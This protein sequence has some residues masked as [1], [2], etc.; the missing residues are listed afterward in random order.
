MEVKPGRLRAAGRLAPCIILVLGCASDRGTVDAGNSATDGAL[1]EA[2]GDAASPARPEA[3]TGLTGGSACDASAQCLSGACTLGACSDWPHAMRIRI[4][5][6]AAGAD[7]REAV[8]DFPLLLRLDATNFPFAEAR[9]DGTDIRFVDPSGRSLSHEVERWDGDSGVAALWV[10]VPRIEGDSRN[11]SVLM[12]WGNSL[13]VPTSSGPSV[14][15]AFACVLHMG[16]APDGV[17]SHLGDSSGQG[18]IGL[19]QNPTADALSADGIAGLGL[20]LDGRSTYLA[21][22]VASTSPPPFSVSLWLKTTSSTHA[23]IAGFASKASGNDV[24]FDRA[25]EM[26]ES[27]R[28]AFGVLNGGHLLTVSTLTGYN[29]GAWHLIVARLSSG[30]QYLFVDGEPVAD[31]PT[32]SGEDSYNGY[33]RFGEEPLP[34]PPPATTD[35][36]VPTGNFFSGALDEIRVT[37]DEPSDARIKLAYATQRPGTNAVSYQPVP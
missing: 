8:A 10:L 24:K 18:N 28:L 16:G 26:D 1:P 27:G 37:T 20:A 6:T 36:A 19:V 4:D 22:N 13:A 30:G 29:D 12:Y 15:G 3:R 33:W 35:A 21:T 25:I 9:R 34:S 23:G 2:G 11:N 14:F 31:D 32:H 7:I 17:S 5:T